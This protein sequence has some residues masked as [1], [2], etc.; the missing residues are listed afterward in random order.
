MIKILTFVF[1]LVIIDGVFAHP[2]HHSLAILDYNKES[3]QL[4]LSFKILT[5]D[6]KKLAKS[7]K[8]EEY[9][10]RYFKIS[11]NAHELSGDFQGQE[12]TFEYTWL[13]FTYHIEA[14]ALENNSRITIH[15]S[16]LLSSNENQFNTVKFNILD[17]HFSH[18][19]SSVEKRHTFIVTVQQ[20]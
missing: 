20:N 4:E 8:V 14:A 17:Q 7:H 18:N 2:H 1:L 5:E 10:D 9:I 11:V 19:F 6:Y 16:I 13:Y 3:K 15:N 12:G